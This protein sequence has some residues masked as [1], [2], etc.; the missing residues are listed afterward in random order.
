MSQE[1]AA[2]T[3][4][5]R[6]VPLEEIVSHTRRYHPRDD[7]EI[8]SRAYE[9]AKEAHA[10][11]VRMSGEPYFSHP[12]N[13]ALI[14][15][16]IMMDP[17]TI[18]AGLLHDVVEDV[19][20]VTGETIEKLFSA[21]IGQMVDGVTKLNHVDFFSKH[22]Q[23]TESIR[24]M[25]MAMAK[26]IRVV[27]IK[28]ADRLHN[29][30]T[31]DTQKPQRRQDIAQETLDIYAPLAHRLGVYAI[32]SELEDLCLKY[33]DP[34]EYMLIKQKTDE[35]APAQQ[36]LIS[37]IQRDLKAALEAEGLKGFEI[38]GRIKHTYSIYRKMKAQK[39]TYE[40]I[41]DLVAVRV[42]VEQLSD[43]YSVLGIVHSIWQ[44]MPDRIKDYIHSPK[45]GIYQSLHT[46]VIDKS[47]QRFEVQIRTFEMHQNAEYGIAAHWRYKEGRAADELDD[48]LSWLRRIIDWS[49]ET[50]DADEF[51]TFLRTDLF[52]DDVYVS[53]P[54]GDIISL[55]RGATPIDFAYRIH[56]A[57]G[58][59]CVGARVDRKMVPLSTKLE[60]GNL[61]EV[62]T[63]AASKGPS[64]DWLNIVVTGEAKAKIRA[65]LK[66]AS[67]DENLARGRD[68][69]ERELKRMGLNYVDLFK[70]EFLETLYRRY[71]LSG[72]DD[73]YVTVGFGGL[74][75]PQIINRLNDEYRKSVKQEAKPIESLPEKVPA[76]PRTHTTQGV[77]VEGDASMLVRFARCCNPLP[78]DKIV[79]Y[80]TNGRGVSIHRADCVNMLDGSIEPGRMVRVN[81][82]SEGK[83][84]YE[85]EIQVRSYDKVG[86]LGDLSNLF[87][88]L[89][90]PLL[91]VAARSLRNGTSQINLTLE[92][93]DTG[94][95]DKVIRQL[96]KRSDILEVFRTG[97]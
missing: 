37:D 18:A 78:G 41:M 79:G 34:A 82:A 29:M 68:L 21:E 16:D 77:E 2:D 75:A 57:V 90:V 48:K 86:L 10:G 7:M 8:I 94:Q 17:A 80:V 84:S 3:N 39:K 43:C 38:S 11:Q 51:S 23:K 67:K 93:K 91:A 4:P 70:T 87:A 60:S 72:L 50:G 61:V 88:N 15:A 42:V 62:I 54:A 66:N 1:Y 53:T 25:F 55:P 24:K 30:R 26:E 32:K 56:T 89:E 49:S 44:P 65:F 14:L 9:Y 6:V 73:L 58:N 71:S 59:R 64:L 22:Q 19:E 85:A 69:I 28:L 95:L 96:Q 33:L 63:S 12:T 27:L 20:G 35:N 46:T 31:L 83:S 76:K 92:I 5:N 40:Q 81:W 52:Q 47:G 74:S 13:V 97:M 36:K 45:Y